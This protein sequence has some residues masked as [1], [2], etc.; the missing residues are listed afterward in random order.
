M[1]GVGMGVG[2]G[3][4]A[5][6][7]LGS[8]ADFPEPRSDSVIG[9]AVDGDTLV[10]GT[11]VGVGCVVGE[12]TPTRIAVRP[13]SE[14]EH[15]TASAKND[16]KTTANGNPCLLLK[17]LLQGQVR[18]SR[19][20]YVVHAEV[21][22]RLNGNLTICGAQSACYNSSKPRLGQPRREARP[23]TR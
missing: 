13:G 16:R 17:G 10:G 20:R 1:V 18:P 5:F 11:R 23:T 8:G 4:V 21:K 7:W 19:A 14:P 6:V 3:T 12:W 2:V 22:A 15:P 9:P